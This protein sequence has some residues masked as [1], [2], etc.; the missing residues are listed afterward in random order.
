MLKNIQDKLARELSP[1]R[2]NHSI[3][4]S[5]TAA[6]LAV[7]YGADHEKA[8]LAGL[9][10]DCA[11][12]MPNN[13]LLKIVETSAIVIDG[14]EKIQPELLHAP[15]GAY[16][17]RRDYGIDDQEICQAIASHTVGGPQMKLLDQI[18]FLADFIEP[19]RDFPGV[20][21]L[22]KLAQVDLKKALLAAYDQTILY[23]V[24]KEGLIHNQAIEG[25]NLL[26]RQ[27]K[28]Q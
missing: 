21:K 7:I 3:G 17:A 1:K 11:R 16:I 20:E 12:E 23:L 9:L 26:L 28:K 10:H 6:G 24:A 2:L 14:V 8:G 15:V 27:Q 18:I 19:G 22:R 13:I 25:R 4:V 5:Q